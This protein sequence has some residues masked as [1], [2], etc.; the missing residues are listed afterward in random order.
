MARGVGGWGFIFT[1]WLMITYHI[2]ENHTAYSIDHCVF[3]NGQIL[4][5]VGFMTMSSLLQDM[6]L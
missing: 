6:I 4:Y 5:T 1:P 2:L 3:S